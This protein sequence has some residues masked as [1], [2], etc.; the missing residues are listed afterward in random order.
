MLTREIVWPGASNEEIELAVR[1]GKRVIF[2]FLYDFLND[3]HSTNDIIL[4]PPIPE[5]LEDNPASVLLVE[6]MQHC[7]NE[8]PSQ[9]PSFKDISAKLDP[10]LNDSALL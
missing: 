6:L 2:F 3:S 8:A 7:W 5:I 9:R 1:G 4:Q 10:L